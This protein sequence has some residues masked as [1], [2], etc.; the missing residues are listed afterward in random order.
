MEFCD[1]HLTWLGNKLSNKDYICFYNL[2][3]FLNNLWF[4]SAWLGSNPMCRPISSSYSVFHAN[5]IWIYPG[6]SPLESLFLIIYF[7]EFYCYICGNHISSSTVKICFADITRSQ[8]VQPSGR[9]FMLLLLLLSFQWHQCKA[10]ARGK[11]LQI[12]WYYVISWFHK[13]TYFIT[14]LTHLSY[15]RKAVSI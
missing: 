7:H 15:F 12:V 6:L 8:S 2:R 13:M 4:Y 11:Q 9:V 5:R 10:S 1:L 3:N 14:Y